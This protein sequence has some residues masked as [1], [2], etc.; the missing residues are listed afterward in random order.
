MQ[1]TNIECPECYSRGY[2][3]LRT[4]ND[5]KLPDGADYNFREVECLSCGFKFVTY[6]TLD[7][8]QV[9][10]VTGYAH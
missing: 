7:P 6:E 8:P 10:Y 5:R 4:N 1:K 3:V 2:K 9:E